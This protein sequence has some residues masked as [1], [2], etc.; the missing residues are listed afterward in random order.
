MYLK[1]CYLLVVLLVLISATTTNGCFSMPQNQID[2]RKESTVTPQS[3]TVPAEPQDGDPKTFTG[4]TS[5]VGANCHS[6]LL[7]RPRN[8]RRHAC[9]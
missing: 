9:L 2:E 5:P 7:Q 1:K 6:S 4:G 8:V 3:E